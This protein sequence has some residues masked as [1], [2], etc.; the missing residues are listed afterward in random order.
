MN[1][2]ARLAAVV[3]LCAVTFAAGAA[4]AFGFE[5]PNDPSSAELVESPREFDGTTI[6]FEGEAIGESMVRGDHAWLH[7]NDDAY[8]YENVEEGARLEGYNSGMP[9]WL[10]ADL[11]RRVEV[12]GDY[13]H[14]G[15]VVRVIGTYN[16]ACAEHGGDTDIHAT[17]LTVLLPGRDAEDPVEPWKIGLTLVMTGAAAA[18]ILADRRLGRR[19]LL[20]MARARR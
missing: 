11:A 2:L 9:V 18:V 13:K 4:P 20:G 16:A 7:L 17:E 6:T 5:S 19:E 1:R 8:M 10:P 14:E 12:F 3:V 15:D